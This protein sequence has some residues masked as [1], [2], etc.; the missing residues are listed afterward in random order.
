MGIK[1]GISYAKER[2]VTAPLPLCGEIREAM[3]TAKAAG[4]DG[5]EIHGREFEFT[6]QEIQLIKAYQAELDLDICAIATGRLYNQ[7]LIS[8]T[9][10]DEERRAWSVAQTKLYVDAAAELDTDVIIGWLRGRKSD[11]LTMEQYLGLLADSLRQ[12]DEYA[13]LR[14]VKILLE[15]INRYEVDSFI[16]AEE[17]LNFINQHHLNHT[18]LHLDTFHMNIEETDLCDA[19]RTTGNKL[20]YVHVADNTRLSPGTGSLDFKKIFDVLKE[21]GYDGYATVECFP[22][23]SGEEAANMAGAY[24]SGMK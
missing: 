2:P 21:I 11:Q 20:G 22:Y 19:I 5:I 12:M 3:K 9:D 4:F 17:T 23:P 6:P 7:T 14:N 13:G 8:L 10:P 24:L 15:A 1:I 18:Y 16:T